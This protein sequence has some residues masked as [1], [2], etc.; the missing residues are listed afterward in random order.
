[1]ELAK[2]YA[3]P[4]TATSLATLC[5]GDLKYS[6]GIALQ[7]PQANAANLYFG[8]QFKQPIFV[9]P[10]GSTAVM[11]IS[12]LSDIYVLGT[13]GDFINVIIF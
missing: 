7:A 12:S 9:N 11:P 4:T 8:T 5:G 13:S 3:A 1:M 2:Q 10:G 6:K